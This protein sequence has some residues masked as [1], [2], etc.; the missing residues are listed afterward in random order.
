MLSAF[1][2]HQVFSSG[3]STSAGAGNG[4]CKLL[5][6]GN[7]HGITVWTSNCS[8]VERLEIIWQFMHNIHT[9]A[10]FGLLLRIILHA[11]A[12]ADG[13]AVAEVVVHAAEER[14]LVSDCWRP[15]LIGD[16]IG[17][18]ESCVGSGT[19]AALLAFPAGVLTPAP[20]C[21]GGI[22]RPLKTR[23]LPFDMSDY[24]GHTSL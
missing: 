24:G 22:V 15:I 3:K 11:R 4:V 6:S 16:G 1:C 20:T 18:R 2:K 14:R 13:V 23:K 21:F 12:R 19:G 8:V 10:V 5:G 7:A 9:Q 17:S